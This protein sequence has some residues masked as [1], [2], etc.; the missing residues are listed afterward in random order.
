MNYALFRNTVL[1]WIEAEG[2]WSVDTDWEES[3]GDYPA[4]AAVSADGKPMEDFIELEQER[5]AF[6]EF[7]TISV[8]QLFWAYREEG[9]DAVRRNLERFL[10]RE[11]KTVEK[12][13]GIDYEARLDRDGVIL[14]RKLRGLRAEI[15]A[16]RRVPPYIVFMN[17]SLFEMCV[18]RPGTMEE[19][20]SLYGVGKKNSADYGEDFLKAIR[21]YSNGEE[22][23][24]ADQAA[25]AAA[26][27]EPAQHEPALT[28]AEP[29]PPAPLSVA[30]ALSGLAVSEATG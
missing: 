7:M 28:P 24:I 17:R 11:S 25:A 16:R 8:N 2:D 26:S 5:G 1:E 3:A 22:A 18:N 23:A 6:Y 4:G 19:L 15:A 14:Y 9:W 13:R 21:E 27:A 30:D 12:K 29:A 10:R 20:Q